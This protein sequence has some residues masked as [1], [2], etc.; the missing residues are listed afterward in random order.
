MNYIIVS[1]GVQNICTKALLFSNV[2]SSFNIKYR[3]LKFSMV[4]LEMMI[5]GTVSQILYL[6]LSF[7]F[8]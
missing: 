4:I 8:M 6:G 2:A 1:K 5:E 7:L 3:K